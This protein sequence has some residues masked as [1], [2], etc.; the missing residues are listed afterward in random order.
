MADLGGG[1]GG[2]FKG[3]LPPGSPSKRAQSYVYVQNLDKMHYCYCALAHKP[4][5][6]S[7]V[8]LVVSCEQVVKPCSRIAVV[9]PEVLY[10]FKCQQR[11]Y[12]IPLDFCTYQ[13]ASS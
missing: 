4:I 7:M 2:G 13:F 11:R 12:N 5:A 3:L 10:L 8:V 6:M 9:K 1:G